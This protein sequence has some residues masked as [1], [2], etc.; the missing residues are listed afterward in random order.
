MCSILVSMFCFPLVMQATAAL[1]HTFL[2][3]YLIYFIW[4]AVIALYT[5]R[6][7]C[8]SAVSYVVGGDFSSL[9]IS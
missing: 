6:D 9:C 3:N 2:E 7:G 1:S 5:S 4:A 8:D